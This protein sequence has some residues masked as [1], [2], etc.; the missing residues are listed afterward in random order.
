MDQKVST[1][2][3]ELQ[4]V[5]EENNALRLMLED[6]RRKYKNLQSYLLEIKNN[7]HN[8]DTNKRT[9]LKEFPTAKKPLQVY[10]RTHPNDD[11]LIIKDGYEWRK[12][13]QK[14]TKDNASPRAYFRCS[15]APNCSAKKKVQ[16]SVYDRSIIVATYDG[17]H[18]HDDESFLPSSS[19][20]KDSFLPLTIIQNY[21]EALNIDHALSTNKKPC[22]DIMDY[23]NNNKN[24]MKIE[25]YVSSLMNDPE[26]TVTIAEAVA[27]SIIAQPKQ[28]CLNLNLGLPQ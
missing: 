2:E 15:M 7:V 3:V 24:N 6:Q 10:V 4:H 22:K 16:R 13:G 21:K 23:G 26:F 19:T 1:L 25:E 9:R 28:Q 14:V 11:S 27:H 20:P 17:E 5:K 18:N 8:L 12:Y